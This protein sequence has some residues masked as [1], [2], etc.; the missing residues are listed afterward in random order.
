MPLC[1]HQAL[2]HSWCLFVR[3]PRRRSSPGQGILG[4]SP[5]RR[6]EGLGVGSTQSREAV[7]SRRRRQVV[8]ILFEASHQSASMCS[9]NGWDG[10]KSSGP[11]ELACGWRGNMTGTLAGGLVV[12]F[13]LARSHRPERRIAMAGRSR[14]GEMFL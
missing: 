7:G 10:K 13:Y 9:R 4:L 12:R 8:L 3:S 6:N 11:A 2:M 1:S 14:S 5:S